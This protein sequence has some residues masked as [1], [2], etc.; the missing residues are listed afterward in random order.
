MGLDDVTILDLEELENKRE[1]Y[2][3]KTDYEH[4][5]SMQMQ[6]LAGLL[7]FLL[8]LQKLAFTEQYSILPEFCFYFYVR[9]E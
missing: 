7:F 1:C 8:L 6:K 3:Y 9:F 4:C 5:Y 2:I